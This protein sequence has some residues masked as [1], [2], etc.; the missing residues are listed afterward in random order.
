MFKPLI[1][2]CTIL[3]TLI[4]V[5]NCERDDIC[6]EE[7]RESPDLIILMLD[8]ENKIER[9]APSDFSILAIGNNKELP[10]RGS[11]DSV[12]LP[13]KIQ[14]NIVQFEFIINQ[15][16]SN[17][18]IDTLQINYNRF[19]NF[20]NSACGFRSNYI[21]EKSPATILNPGNNWIKGFTILR[22]TISDETNA[23]LGIL[24]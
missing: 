4:L 22:D 18:N 17:E 13:L 1:K 6:I 15:G 19:D 3:L 16:T 21:L 8:I 20:I 9:K 5:T 24:H 10:A 2:F 14:E 11:L 23:H 7:I 12:V